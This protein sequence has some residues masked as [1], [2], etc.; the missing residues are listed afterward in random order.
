M[1]IFGFRTRKPWKM[2]LASFTYGIVG[3]GV[4][5]AIVSPSETEEVMGSIETSVSD[6]TDKNGGKIEKEE[7][8]EEIVTEE[9]VEEVNEEVV[10]TKTE[11]TSV[12]ETTEL[13]NIIATLDPVTVEE[14]IKEKALKDWDKDYTMQEY[15]IKNQ[16]ESYKKLLK[17]N[18]DEEVK[19]IL[20]EKAFDDWNYDFTMVEYVYTNQMEAFKEV[21]AIID[22]YDE[23]S[24]EY[25]ILIDSIDMWGYDFTMVLYAYEQQLKSYN[26]LNR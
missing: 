16:T 11:V 4:L 19:Q 13:Y 5:G 26:N 7:K 15:V 22:E 17:V 6:I 25:E 3:L 21:V 23:G 12:T 8:D 1:K 14:Q 18:V 2:L 9:T 10:D 24:P 20:L